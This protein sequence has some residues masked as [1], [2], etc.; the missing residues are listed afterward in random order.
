MPAQTRATDIDCPN[1]HAKAG[2]VC[3]GTGVGTD[4][5]QDRINAAVATTREANRRR[6][7]KS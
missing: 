7:A 5:C 4:L 2:E 6:K 1:G 3:N